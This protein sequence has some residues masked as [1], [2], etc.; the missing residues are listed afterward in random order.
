M[1]ACTV[2]WKGTLPVAGEVSRDA[3]VLLLG[4]QVAWGFRS[5]GLVEAGTTPVC[6]P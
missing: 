2:G 3:T 1:L 5:D 4:P 6:V